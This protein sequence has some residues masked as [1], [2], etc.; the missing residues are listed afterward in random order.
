[1]FIDFMTS[2]VP[3]VFSNSATLSSSLAKL[4]GLRLL[5][6]ASRQELVSSQWRGGDTVHDRTGSG[7]GDGAGDNLG[8]KLLGD[9]VSAWEVEAGGWLGI[10]ATV[11]PAS[12]LL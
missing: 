8:D 10:L 7:D 3:P 2:K 4:F 6:A 5:E 9:S 11:S 12:K 1:M